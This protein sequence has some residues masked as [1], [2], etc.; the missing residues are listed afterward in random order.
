M[1]EKLTL[2]ERIALTAK[3]HG[4]RVTWQQLKYGFKRAAIECD[5]YEEMYAVEKIF[6]N[7]GGVSISSWH[8]SDGGFFEGRVYVMGAED[9]A[10]LERQRSEELARV[11][12][13]WQRYHVADAETR[14]L[15]ACGAIQ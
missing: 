11:E 2:D 4:L 12:A 6:K 7:Q 5:S 14:R 15:M 13:W 1:K 8:C 9:H 10:E 3:R